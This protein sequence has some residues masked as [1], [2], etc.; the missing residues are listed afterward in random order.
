MVRSGRI[1]EAPHET[2]FKVDKALNRG[3]RGLSGHSSLAKLLAEHKGVRNHMDLPPLTAKQI[4]VWA[5][6]HHARTGNWPKSTSGSITDAQGETWSGVGQLLKIG[7]RGLPGGD[8]LA[9]LLSRH[10]GVPHR[11][12]MPRLSVKRIVAWAKAHHA[13][14][15]RW[16]S[17]YSGAIP[18]APGETWAGVSESLRH[19]RRG[20]PP[21]GSLYRLLRPC[22]QRERTK[23]R[24]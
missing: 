10:R 7:L 21:G 19:G 23:T 17:H 8:S 2:W 22:R 6:A 16:P 1:A 13:R 4:L 14:T 3:Q 5:D 15:G 18:D 12:H 11:L 24:N 20:L 9:R